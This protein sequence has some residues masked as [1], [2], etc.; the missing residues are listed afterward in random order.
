MSAKYYCF[1]GTG[2]PNQ[3][4]VIESAD[5]DF[6]GETG[7]VKASDYDALKAAALEVLDS[8]LGHRLEADSVDLLERACGKTYLAE[9]LRALRA[10]VTP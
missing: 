1:L 10:L 5:A 6:D 4:G 9:R 3:I 2:V 8:A 7:Y